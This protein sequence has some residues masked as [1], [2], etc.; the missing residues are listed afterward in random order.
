MTLRVRGCCLRNPQS[1]S[2]VAA[3]A[4]EAKHLT[5]APLLCWPTFL[6]FLLLF[7]LTFLRRGVSA[8]LLAIMSHRFLDWICL[9]VHLLLSVLPPPRTLSQTRL[10]ILI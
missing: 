4:V 2:L 3:A 7:L 1:H 9:A 8:R 5:L 6:P 10:M